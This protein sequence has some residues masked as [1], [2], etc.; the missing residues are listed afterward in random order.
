MNNTAEKNTISFKEAKALIDNT[1]FRD[2]YSQE[3]SKNIFVA[4]AEV[5]ISNCYFSSP[6]YPFPKRMLATDQTMGAFLFII[7]DVTIIITNTIFTS[8]LAQYGGAIY[9]SG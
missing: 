9:I 1:K 5:N 7:L 2:N 6:E 3:R 8:G 4:F